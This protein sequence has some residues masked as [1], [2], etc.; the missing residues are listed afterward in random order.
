MLRYLLNA[1][2]CPFCHF[3]D[4]SP[5]AVTM[6][7]FAYIAKLSQ[8]T[9]MIMN[10]DANNED[11]GRRSTYFRD[12]RYFSIIVFM[13][14]LMTAALINTQAGIKQMADLLA[15]F[16]L[17]YLVIGITAQLIRMRK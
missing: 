9:Y 10:N 6:L 12:I 3:N 2:N 4:S 1:F 15:F 5:E 7:I 11:L 17:G 13:V 8:K 16:V 14:S